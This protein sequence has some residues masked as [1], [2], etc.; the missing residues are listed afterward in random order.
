MY[1][2]AKLDG[3][4]IPCYRGFVRYVSLRRLGDFSDL[5]HSKFKDDISFIVYRNYAD[6]ERDVALGI[7]TTKDGNL[8]QDKRR[9][10]LRKIWEIMD[11]EV[12]YAPTYAPL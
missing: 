5:N 11:R 1:Q 4:R 2:L 3:D 9:T 7:Y 10:A 6:R 12:K 8:V